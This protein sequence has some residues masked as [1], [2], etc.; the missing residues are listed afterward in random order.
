MLT[1]VSAT[2]DLQVAEIGVSRAHI[3]MCDDGNKYVVKFVKTNPT[4]NRTVVNELVAGCLANH[5]G[6]PNPQTVLVSISSDFIANSIELTQDGVQ[7]GLHIGS[8]YV[9]GQNFNKFS[10]QYARGRTLSNG[11]D[12]YGVIVFDNLV[13]NVDRNN[14]GNN[15]LDLLQNNEAY[16]R[17]IDFGHCFTGDS[18]TIAV[19]QARKED[20]HIVECFW[21]ISENTLQPDKFE[22]WFTLIEGMPDEDVERILQ[23]IP[24]GWAIP[25]EER[26]ALK[27]LVSF[28]KSRIRGIVSASRG[29]LQ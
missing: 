8:K 10:Q 2:I 7:A 6:L 22:A 19:L 29:R 9:S 20:T 27:D 4:P 28:R 23:D 13:L 18:W 15:L 11:D 21:Y 16:Y 25:T 5:L 1:T 26:S 24:E 3:M 14:S 17:M 12:L